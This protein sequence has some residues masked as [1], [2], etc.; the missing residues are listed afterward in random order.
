MF[1]QNINYLVVIVATI[2]GMIAGFVWYAPWAFG[3]I[4]M[5]A[6][7]SMLE[8]PK[9]SVW[10]GMV[11]ST[12]ITAF[13]LAVLFNS[14]VIIGFW[15][16]VCTAFLLW[17]GFALPIKLGDYYFGGE[18]LTIFLLSVGQELFVLVLMSLLI[19]IFG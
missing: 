6:K 5:K 7:G 9:K 11:I 16:I 10:V 8:K 15:G 12:F 18:S 2:V 3:K 17:L 4:W 14:L 1:F 13:I 19:G